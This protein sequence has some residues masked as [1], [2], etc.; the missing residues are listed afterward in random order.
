[1]GDEWDIFDNVRTEEAASPSVNGASKAKAAETSE[2]D[3]GSSEEESESSEEEIF[4][5]AQDEFN[6][7]KAGFVSDALRGIFR[8]KE[9]LDMDVLPGERLHEL[10]HGHK[11]KFLEPPTEGVADEWTLGYVRRYVGLHV[12]A[13]HFHRQN[14]E[15]MMAASM[16]SDA[17]GMCIF[18]T[19]NNTFRL[20]SLDSIPRKPDSPVYLGCMT[21]STSGKQ[22]TIYD[23]RVSDPR[24]KSLSKHV[25]HDIAH[26]RYE[27]NILA[28]VPNSMK[29]IVARHDEHDALKANFMTLA[30]RYDAEQMKRQMKAEADEEER[31]KNP[32]KKI[33][34]KEY[35]AV[36]VMEQS[37]LLL[38]RTKQPVWNEDLQ[39]WTLN[40]D[41]RVKKASKKNFLLETQDVFHLENEF[42]ADTEQLRFGKVRKNVYSLDFKY[43]FSPVQAFGC[44]LTTFAKKLLVT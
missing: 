16:T 5:L 44:A 28:R 12:T 37:Q 31:K 17:K 24:S 6:D 22:F 21:Y 1:M 29:V 25:T 35:A 19:I 30:E 10:M 9:K 2:E 11:T 3:S 39:A 41:G 43:P 13:W 32:D 8:K 7:G 15:F 40:F 42:G 20:S 34:T 23:Y 33:V 27:T 18:S 26:I 38:F 14:G 36:G 4:E